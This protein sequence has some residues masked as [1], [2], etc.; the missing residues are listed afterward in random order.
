[1]SDR[2]LLPALPHSQD[3]ERGILSCFLHDEDLLKDAAQSLPVAAFYCPAERYLYELLLKFHRD[4][5]PI[6][7]IAISHHVDSLGHMDKIGGP[8]ALAVLL[9]F[10]PT[11]THYGYYKG[12]LLDAKTKRDLYQLGQEMLLAGM[13]LAEDPKPILEKFATRIKALST[14]GAQPPSRPTRGVL[15]LCETEIDEGLTLLGDRFLCTGG[16]MVFIG[17]SGVGKSS[18]SMQQDVCFALGREAF[19]IQPKRPLKILTVQAEN[20]DGDLKEMING[21]L[22]GVEGLGELSEEE[23]TLLN[24][25]CRIVTINDKSGDAFLREL[26]GLL[27][28]H[29]PDIV[30]I[31]PLMAYLGGDPTDTELLSTFLRAGLNP[32]LARHQ[33]AVIIN[34]HTPKVNNRDTSKWTALDFSYSGLGSSELVNWARCILTIEKTSDSKVFK[35]I[36]A[37]KTSRIGWK[38]PFGNPEEMR[39]FEHS[40][41]P[42]HICWQD[43]S[44]ASVQS[45]TAKRGKPDIEKMIMDLVPATDAIPK[46][47][48]VH[49]IN[50][51]G[52]GKQSIKDVLGALIVAREPK[53]FVWQRWRSGTNAEPFIGRYP[54]PQSDRER[55]DWRETSECSPFS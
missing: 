51:T 30:R 28:L 11:P 27:E 3:A 6:E 55:R 54:Q 45:A 33:C 50:R 48:L 32:L 52:T 1:M 12:L 23:R 40:K 29:K 44:D 2:K 8:G 17:P 31:D 10:V 37:K 9:D 35:F 39:L 41:E 42:G 49:L 36:A 53:L 21:V 5:K 25:N 14:A 46:K 20:D 18:A 16:G 13:S 38:D 19:G 7:Y 26:D 34:H 43:A 24:T 22:K 47:E 4:G 15:E